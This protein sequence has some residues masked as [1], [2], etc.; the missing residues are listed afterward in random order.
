MRDGVDLILFSASLRAL[1]NLN[2]AHS[3][4][5][6]S[7]R[8]FCRPLLLLPR[9]VPC[10]IVLTTLLILKHAQT[11]LTY[12]SLPWLTYHRKAHGLA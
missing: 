8:F 11:T 4:I 7:Q 3:E 12:V 9:T 2:S 10:K 5:L 6:F 1:Q